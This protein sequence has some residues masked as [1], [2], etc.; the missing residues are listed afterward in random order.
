MILLRMIHDGFLA[1]ARAWRAIVLLALLS[2]ISAL[3][4]SMLVRGQWD[5]TVQSSL[6]SEQL[7][8]GFDFT[9]ITEVIQKNPGV[10]QAVVSGVLA[11]LLLHALAVALV[12]GGIIRAAADPAMPRTIRAILSAGG[13][14]AGRFLRLM[15]VEAVLILVAGGIMVV[16]AAVVVQGFVQNA[17]RETSII[18]ALYTFGAL[19]VIV[20]YLL[21]A[22]GDYGRVHIVMNGDRSAFKS[23]FRG[24]A[25]HL[26]HVLPA[27]SMHALLAGGTLLMVW[28]HWII[29]DQISVDSRLM[30]AATFVVFELIMLVRSGIRVW[31]YGSA[32]VLW[33]SAK[34][35]SV[36]EPSVAPLPA[37]ISPAEPSFTQIIQSAPRMAE[38]EPTQRRRKIRSRTMAKKPQRKPKSSGR[39]RT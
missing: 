33:N 9:V 35:S 31:N 13:E 34:A 38:P 4:V 17:E 26:R 11:M 23:Y 16:A 39:K 25:F 20:F 32:V 36:P 7:M 1:T 15:L 21:L 27:A 29:D 3:P 5:K 30:I 2:A 22:W 24:A 10:T 37:M 18:N 14:Y 8:E 19:G 28:L 6:F 12:G